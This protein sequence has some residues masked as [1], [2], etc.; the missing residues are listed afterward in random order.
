MFHIAYVLYFLV[1]YSFIFFEIYV[2]RVLE[3]N[4]LSGELPPELGNLLNIQQM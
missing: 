3:A 4:E 1:I 2:S